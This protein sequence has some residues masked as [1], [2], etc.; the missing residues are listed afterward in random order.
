[1]TVVEGC[2]F[3]DEAKQSGFSGE[4]VIHLYPSSGELR[5]FGGVRFAISAASDAIK[6]TCG[7]CQLCV[8]VPVVL[9]ANVPENAGSAGVRYFLHAGI[10]RVVSG[11]LGGS[12]FHKIIEARQKRLR[13]GDYTRIA[14]TDKPIK[15]GGIII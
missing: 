7:D 13:A 14:I 9:R 3:G 1:M 10:V 5:S 12:K 15:S 2:K 4:G 6:G 11:V 8:P